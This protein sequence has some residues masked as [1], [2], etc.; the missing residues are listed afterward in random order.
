MLHPK[1]PCPHFTKLASQLTHNVHGPHDEKF[2]KLLSELEDEYEALKQ[3]GYD[4]EGFHAKGN[5]L[6]EY[7]SHNL[8]PHLAR[9]RALEAAE[10]RR[11]I[12]SMM[13]GPRRLGGAVLSRNMSP[14]ELAA[15]VW[16][17]MF[18]VMT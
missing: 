18:S 4:G 9:S 10:N 15:Q 1:L 7:V 12:G 13:G 16:H 14:R 17:A 8:P 5:R 2:Y 3:S 11:R 6:G